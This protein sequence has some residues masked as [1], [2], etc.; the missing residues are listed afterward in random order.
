MEDKALTNEEKRFAET[1]HIPEEHMI[2]YRFLYERERR[3]QI[4]ITVLIC[5]IVIIGTIAIIA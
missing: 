3:Y 1:Y 5:L 2:F 4:I